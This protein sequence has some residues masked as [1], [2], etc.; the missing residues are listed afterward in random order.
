MIDTGSA[1]WIYALGPRKVLIQEDK[2]I[3]QIT[4]KDKF[5]YNCYTSYSYRGQ[6][7]TC[8]LNMN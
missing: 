1:L 6:Y 7:P 3:T 4:I 5:Y 8:I 2:S